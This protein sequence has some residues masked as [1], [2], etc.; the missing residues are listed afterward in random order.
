MGGEAPIGRCSHCE[1]P[2]ESYM[3]C[4]NFECNKLHL[5]C[6]DCLRLHRGFCSV[7]CSKAPRRRQI[8]IDA[9][10]N[11]DDFDVTAAMSFTQGAPPDVAD[12]NKL[13]AFKPHNIARKDYDADKHL[14]VEAVDRS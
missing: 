3:N 10:V 7:D 2:C 1:A 6:K 4:C 8:L 13:V 11:D 14:S 5:V 12:P 9:D